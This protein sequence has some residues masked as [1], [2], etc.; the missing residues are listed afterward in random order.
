MLV[1]TV[2]L[3]TITLLM[4]IANR[5]SKNEIIN[6]TCIF[7]FVCGFTGIVNE[8]ATN[9]GFWCNVFNLNKKTFYLIQAILGSIPHFTGVYLTLLYGVSCSNI[10]KNKKKKYL[11]YLILFIPALLSYVF[12]PYKAPNQMSE[13]ERVMFFVK[14]AVWTIPYHITAVL[15]IIYRWRKEKQI[16]NERNTYWFLNIIVTVPFILTS[17]TL[18]YILRIFTTEN[19]GNMYIYIIP[20]QVILF[21]YFAYKNGVLGLKIKLENYKLVVTKIFDYIT[22]SIIVLDENYKIIEINK[23]FKNNFKVSI[24]STNIDNVL[25][26][27]LLNQYKNTIIEIIKSKTSKNIHLKIDN[28]YFDLEVITLIK[29]NTFEGIFLIV[30]D[31]TEYRKNIL[32]LKENQEQLIEKERYATFSHLASGLAHNLKTPLMTVLGGVEIFQKTITKLKNNSLDNLDTIIEKQSKWT[33]IIKKSTLNV[34]NAIR[35]IQNHS[36]KEKSS[37]LYS[38]NEILDEINLFMEFEFIKNNCTLVKEIDVSMDI[39]IEGTIIQVLNTLI[40]NA[41]HS[42]QSKDG[43][44]TI[45]LK[46]KRKKDMALLFEVKD[47]GSGIHPDVQKKLFSEMITT[48]GNEGSGLGLYLTNILVKAKLQGNISFVSN[49]N[50]ST[51]IIEIPP[52]L[53]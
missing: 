44:K 5:K 1:V 37:S 7:G 8:W 25:E 49:S 15:L 27:S 46:I 14:I 22:D 51:F 39:K 11:I 35:I 28:K 30:K 21:I 50:G 19:T 42:Y 2:G 23:S 6:I 32:L 10:F 4:F 34:S 3:W 29:R 47:H 12:L 24:N 53:I 31:V 33:D 16:S 9:I 45:W 40:L 48:K 17:M 41:I 26:S 20:I 36:A 52:L 13:N 38:I 18:N 43:K